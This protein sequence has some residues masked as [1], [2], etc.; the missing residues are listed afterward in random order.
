M[1]L[2]DGKN[3]EGLINLASNMEVDVELVLDCLEAKS[4]EQEV[5]E[6]FEAALN[7]GARGTPRICARFPN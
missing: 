2:L 4:Y 6:D 3:M 7:T 5:T 1:P